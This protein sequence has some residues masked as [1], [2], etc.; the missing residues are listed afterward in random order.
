MKISSDNDKVYKKICDIK[1]YGVKE[2]SDLAAKCADMIKETKKSA[3]FPVQVFYQC[4]I[5]ILE[6]QR[7]YTIQQAWKTR[8]DIRYILFLP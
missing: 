3:Y 6:V 5:L 4:G 7:D 1:V 8:K 2:V